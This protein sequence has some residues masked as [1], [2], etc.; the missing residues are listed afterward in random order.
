M[1]TLLLTDGTHTDTIAVT[2]NAAYNNKI[3]NK[4]GKL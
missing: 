1:H 3:L 4:G 2:V